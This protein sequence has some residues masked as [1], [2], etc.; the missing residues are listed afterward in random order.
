MEK[1]RQP[2]VRDAVI[3]FDEY[4]REC[5]ALLEAVH[6]EVSGGPVPGHEQQEWYVPCVNLMFISP[7]PDKTDGYGRQKDHRSSCVHAS[8]QNPRV[9][10]YW[11]FPEEVDKYRPEE[12]Q[13]QTRR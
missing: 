10:S 5:P 12:D 2:E 11:C 3:Y 1:P 4:R 8:S 7:D 6:G 13:V 9:G